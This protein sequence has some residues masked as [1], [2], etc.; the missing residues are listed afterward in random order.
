MVWGIVLQ[1]NSRILKGL[2]CISAWIRVSCCPLLSC[3]RGRVSQLAAAGFSRMWGSSLLV[4]APNEEVFEG[5][6]ENGAGRG[7]WIK[8][9]SYAME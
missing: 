8:S 1:R 3:P 7:I 5:F 2:G 6:A 9:H 4:S